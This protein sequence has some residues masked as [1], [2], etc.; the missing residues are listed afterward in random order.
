LSGEAPGSPAILNGL[1]DTN[2][3]DLGSKRS[4]WKPKE[5]GSE[6]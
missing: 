1:A 6:A 2:G 3:Y 4:S 5:I